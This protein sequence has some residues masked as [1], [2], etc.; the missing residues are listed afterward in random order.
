MDE[1]IE[2][3]PVVSTPEASLRERLALSDS[4]KRDLLKIGERYLRSAKLDFK[5]ENLAL[6][7]SVL[8]VDCL[9]RGLASEGR[10]KLSELD[11]I[12]PLIEKG[13]QER[14]QLQSE[15]RRA[16]KELEKGLDITGTPLF[17]PLVI[18]YDL[19]KK[20]KIVLSRFALSSNVD[21]CQQLVYEF[22]TRSCLLEVLS[23][24]AISTLSRE[25]FPN[26]SIETI[27]SD[28]DRAKLVRNMIAS[29]VFRQV[30]TA[31]IPIEEL[32]DFI[33]NSGKNLS[34]FDND[35]TNDIYEA[36]S[37][38]VSGEKAEFRN[39][40]AG[41]V[42]QT[43]QVFARPN[44]SMQI[45]L[46]EGEVVASRDAMYE[47]FSRWLL[48]VHPALEERE[49]ITNVKKAESGEYSLWRAD[50]SKE[51]DGKRIPS[52]GGLDRAMRLA[53]AKGYSGERYG[54]GMAAWRKFEAESAAEKAKIAMLIEERYETERLIGR[55]MLEDPV[56]DKLAEK[57]MYETGKPEYS[58]LNALRIRMGKDL[59]VIR[60]A[61]V[62]R[63]K[64]EEFVV[65]LL[66][67]NGGVLPDKAEL[68][69]YELE[70]L[71][72]SKD[73]RKQNILSKANDKLRW[74][75]EEL[76]GEFL[77]IMPFSWLDWANIP[78]ETILL[79]IER[80]KCIE[81]DLIKNGTNSNLDAFRI[82]REDVGS[83]LGYVDKKRSR[84]L[85]R[86]RIKTKLVGDKVRA[87][88]LGL[89]RARITVY[90][91]GTKG[92]NLETLRIKFFKF[93]I[94]ERSRNLK[95]IMIARNRITA[96][97]SLDMEI[98]RFRNKGEIESW[99]KKE[100]ASSF[101]E[102]GDFVFTK[103]TVAKLAKDL[104]LFNTWKAPK[105]LSLIRGL[106]VY[107]KDDF[108]AWLRDEVSE[109]R[110]VEGKTS[111]R[112]QLEGWRRDSLEG[113]ISLVEA[114]NMILPLSY[115]GVS[116][117]DFITAMLWRRVTAEA[118]CSLPKTKFEYDQYLQEFKIIAKEKFVEYLKFH[119]KT[120]SDKIN[121]L[122]TEPAKQR[123]LKKMQGL[124]FVM[125]ES[126]PE[127][128]TV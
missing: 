32:R 53:Y 99:Y 59:K 95:E 57:Y 69:G 80:L 23:G 84:L 60:D 34:E 33:E 104:K 21:A 87:E 76:A 66:A 4:Q 110:K 82:K 25:H 122:E 120:L 10:E 38:N 30:P 52:R 94:M 17:G 114:Q 58:V 7:L 128:A 1:R 36:I 64:S 72:D 101:A 40:I 41:L 11:R 103:E 26:A 75:Y 14:S 29:L 47:K 67:N 56:I 27:T 20:A 13:L 50:L 68:P 118:I 55:A 74:E 22:E 43:K 102:L 71:I 45:P 126:S 63:K 109:T 73:K 89:L 19:Y 107:K 93:C 8:G 100:Q 2:Y 97:N 44:I 96:A 85:L 124:E 39:Y 78:N 12:K 51:I 77:S 37:G 90:Q 119:R 54:E 81:K 106:D 127:K 35:L 79:E 31:A 48:L 115:D 6:A 42:E 16:T 88:E 108:V 116:F 5:R 24:Y 62:R 117:Q 83:I 70:K 3:L 86:K 49:L 121:V 65:Q 112:Q 61:E 91:K 92:A 125:E 113:M 15:V 111:R 98:E 105:S 18:S 46:S 9:S 28:E 123:F